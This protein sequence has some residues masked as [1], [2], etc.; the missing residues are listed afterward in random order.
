MRVDVTVANQTG[1]F[2]PGLEKQ[3]FTLLDNG[4]PRKIVTLQEADDATDDLTTS[5]VLVLDPLNMTPDGDIGAAN[6]QYAEAVDQVESYLKANGGELAWPTVVYRLTK[7]GLYA[8]RTTTDGNALAEEIEQ[9]AGQRRIWASPEIYYYIRNMDRGGELSS[10]ISHSLIALGSIAIEQRR[11]PGRKL[12]FWIGDGWPIEKRKAE[13][14]AD[15][16]IELLT[17]MQEARISLWGASEWPRLDASGN[18]QPVS[19]FVYKEF[20]Q[21]PKQSSVDLRYLTLQVIAARGLG[22]MLF[23]RH[24]QL[25]AT[26]AAQAKKESNYYSLTFDPPRTSLVDEYH[27]LKVEMN[28]PGLTALVDKDYYDQPAFYDQP[29][30]T[31]RVSVKQLETFVENAHNLSKAEF[32]SHLQGME[33]TERLSDDLRVQLVHEV[34]GKQAREAVEVIAD[35]SVFLPPPADEI[36]STP[37]PDM[38]TQKKIIASA[39]TYI[40]TTIPKL[41]DYFANRITVHYHEDEPPAGQSWKTAWAD[42]ALHEGETITA[43]IHL[44][45]G[46][47]RTE[48]VTIKNAPD[49]PGNDQLQTIGTFGPILATVMIAATAPE[50]ELTWNRWEKGESG[51]LAV[52]HYRVPKETPLFSAGFCCLAVDFE[53]IAF[54]TRAPFHGEIAVD[55]STG[56]ILRLTI[57]ADL[58]WRLPLEQSDVMVQYGPVSKGPVTYICPM[59]SVSISRHRRVMALDEWGEHFK[60]YGPF[61]TVM[62]EMRYEKY[63]FFGS[64]FRIVPGFVEA[65]KDQ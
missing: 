44:H 20:L 24:G 22:G 28:R 9:P 14:L 19:D 62:N 30:A 61:E 31:E 65:P 33:L 8:T 52:F 57:E 37:K 45:D 12:M 18:V 6:R 55:P 39:I 54:S 27:H 58:A 17:R 59:R 48:K 4:Q 11:Q 10:R 51:P 36:L 42:H 64:T 53:S 25:A 41:P 1:N 7:D 38:A 60:V 15:F 13:G 50:S 46:K 3:D 43:A 23:A 29:P 32:Q 56:A 2:V 49:K 47:E 34:R 5:V 21:G 26:I 35:K 63:H 40:N 16:S